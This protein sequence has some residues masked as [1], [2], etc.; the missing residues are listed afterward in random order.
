M[1]NYDNMLQNQNREQVE[2]QESRELLALHG[3]LKGRMATSVCVLQSAVDA[4]A[5]CI[6]DPFSYPNRQ[7]AKR[8]LAALSDGI[9]ALERLANNA[10]DLATGAALRGLQPEAFAENLD[11]VRHL[12][13]LC[14]GLN[15]EF[16]LR[17]VTAQLYFDNKAGASFYTAGSPPL[18]DGLLL[19]LITNSLQAKAAVAITLTLQADGSLQYKDDGPGLPPVCADFL[20]QGTMGAEL[21]QRGGTGL[22]LVQD[23]ARALGWQLALQQQ[24]GFVLNIQLPAPV[25]GLP[26][27]AVLYDAAHPGSDTQKKRI[28]RE[29]NAVLGVV[30]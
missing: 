18:V 16:S 13:E 4:F 26:D 9:A 12:E 5:S 17:D 10:A 11:M 23:Y 1:A 20:Q 7:D 8:M 27:A 22:L 3:G 24:P 14:A 6:E 30:K 19:N 2:G 29:L 28:R 25:Q 15:E 21:L